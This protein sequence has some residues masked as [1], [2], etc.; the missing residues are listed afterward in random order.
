MHGSCQSLPLLQPL[1]NGLSLILPSPSS[2]LSQLSDLCS[3]KT[4]MSPTQNVGRGLPHC[5][6][7]PQVEPVFANQLLLH[8][9]LL[10][11]EASQDPQPST[12]SSI[13]TF[14][15]SRMSPK[16]AASSLT[17]TKSS[18]PLGLNFI[19]NSALPEPLEISNQVTNG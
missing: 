11:L 6:M 9:E 7:L 14:R 2:P 1:P 17:S 19:L 18:P 3:S 13:L 12:A 16:M 5:P 10:Y 15:H 8:W 4:S